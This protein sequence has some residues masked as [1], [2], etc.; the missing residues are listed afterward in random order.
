MNKKLIDALV[1]DEKSNK[2]LYSAGPFWDYKCKKILYQIKNIGIQNFRGH[3]SGVGTSFT[4]SIPLD[5][6]NEL[7]IKGRL[8]SKFFTLP[9]LKRIFDQQLNLTKNMIDS[10]LETKAELFK[11]DEEVLELLKKY[12]FENTTKFKCID[13]FKIGN[14]EYSTR[15]FRNASR[16]NHL[17]KKFDYNKIFSYFEIGGGFGSNV[18]FLLTN[19][20]NIKKIL[21][22]DIVPNILVGTEYLRY[23]YGKSV[24]DYLDLKDLDKISFSKDNELEILC[25]PAW[26]IEKFEGEIDHFYNTD[27][28]VEMSNEIVENYANYIKKFN[29]RQIALI[30][31]FQYNNESNTVNY[32]SLNNFFDNKLNI[33]Y[34]KKIASS[35]RQEIIYTSG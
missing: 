29:C 34:T 35:W 28:F 10:Y 33:Q 26:K 27:S 32:K 23:F 30:N 2:G 14:N 12:K 7:N 15:Y 4:D 18:H 31:Y 6:R 13:K 3:N 22:L 9:L 11:K 19:F 5:I 17:C 16:I 20:P 25:I 1:N 24:K 21:Y 8:L